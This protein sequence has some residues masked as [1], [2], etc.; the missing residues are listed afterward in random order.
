MPIGKL[1]FRLRF[2]GTENIPRKALLSFA[3][4]IVPYWTRFF[5]LC[6]CPERFALWQSRSCLKSM[7]N[8]FD[9]F[10]RVWRISSP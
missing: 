8:L 7:D 6:R 10:L 9:G 1:L 3:A 4:T 5:W 2:E